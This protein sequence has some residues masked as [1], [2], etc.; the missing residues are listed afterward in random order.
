MVYLEKMRGDLLTLIDF[1]HDRVE[2]SLIYILKLCVNPKLLHRQTFSLSAERLL[3]DRIFRSSLQA[4]DFLKV[5]LLTM[6]SICAKVREIYCNPDEIIMKQYLMN[7]SNP[8]NQEIP[9]EDEYADEFANEEDE[10]EEDRGNRKK[11]SSA[12]RGRSGSSKRRSRSKSAQRQQDES[13]Q[14]RQFLST[15]KSR[16]TSQINQF[17]E[18]SNSPDRPRT[19]PDALPSHHG[20][21]GKGPVNAMRD[22]SAKRNPR[23]SEDFQAI[24]LDQIDDQN[25]SYYS[26][27]NKDEEGEPEEDFQHRRDSYNDNSFVEDDENNNNRQDSNSKKRSSTSRK[28]ASRSNSEIEEVPSVIDEGSFIP[29][30]ISSRRNS[31]NKPPAQSQ[32]IASTGQYSQDDFLDKSKSRSSAQYTPIDEEQDEQQHQQD[33]EGRPIKKKNKKKGA[34]SHGSASSDGKM[35]ITKKDLLVAQ[36]KETKLNQSLLLQDILNENIHQKNAVALPSLS[37]SMTSN[38]NTAHLHQQT[39]VHLHPYHAYCHPRN[40]RHRHHHPHRHPPHPPPLQNH[41]DH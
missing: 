41:Q 19:A 18:R 33:Q 31:S 34:S 14:Q 29:D 13:N 39:V 21:P 10:E 1:H 6:S 3:Q 4:Y 15:P 12:T 17:R 25:R 37:N 8:M 23:D 2:K 20:R 32:S 11:K 38:K 7:Y 24:P 5:G 9:D 40:H 36:M 30:E 22:F 16:F 26:D 27:F 35:I 28:K